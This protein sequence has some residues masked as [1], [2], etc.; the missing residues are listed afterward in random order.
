MINL[1][2]CIVFFSAPCD[3]VQHTNQSNALVE[4]IQMQEARSY[5]TCRAACCIN[6][7]CHGFEWRDI[8]QESKACAIY[9]STQMHLRPICKRIDGTMR[10]INHYRKNRFE[11]NPPRG[12]VTDGS[13][14]EKP[15]Y[16]SIL[17]FPFYIT[18]K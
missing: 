3:F 18:G 14:F 1:Q 12:N 2:R 15:F 13:K 11:A 16:P 9:V 10:C 6:Y 17:I 8:T 5:D 4:S 7:E